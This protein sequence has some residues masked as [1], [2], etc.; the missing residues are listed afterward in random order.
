MKTIHPTDVLAY[1][2]G[3]QV[4]AGRDSIGGNYVG[5]LVDVV[6]DYDRYVVTGAKPERLRQFRS[7]MLDLRTLLLE[8]PDGEWYLTFADGEYGDPLTLDPQYGHLEQTDFL[9]EPGFLLDDAP[10]DDLALLHARERFNIV[11]EFR[12]EPPEAADAHRIRMA[13]LGGILNHI[14]TV[15]RHA[16]RKAIKDMPTS[17]VSRIDTT[18]AHLMDVVVPA[19]PGSYRVVLEAAK[20]PDLFG[21]GELVKGLQRFDD[22]FTSADNPD[23]ARDL[24]KDHQGHLAGSYIK[25]IKFLAEHNTGL[26][27]SWADGM[28]DNSKHGGVS[29]SV[30]KQLTELLAGATNLSTESV[31]LFGEFERVNRSAGDWG[32]LTDEGVKSGK[33]AEGGPGLDGLQVGKRYIFHCIEDIE[34]DASGRERHILFLQRIENV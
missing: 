21:S 16:Y 3:V 4:F 19:S 1:Y 13:T 6:G 33:V 24:L 28:S 29:E 14:Q 34:M 17:A 23:A 7:G 8:A 10:I 5:M 20:P 11:L 9:P 2:D 25:L 32:L 27:Y 31:T 26:W 12:V 15:V 22:I 30:A 18:D